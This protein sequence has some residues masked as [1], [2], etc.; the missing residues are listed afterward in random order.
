[1]PDEREVVPAEAVLENPADGVADR[2]HRH[3]R[4]HTALRQIAI[5]AVDIAEGRALE[6]EQPGAPLQ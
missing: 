2:R 4:F 6:D 5:V 1:M 3:A